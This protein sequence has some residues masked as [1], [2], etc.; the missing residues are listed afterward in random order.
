MILEFGVVAKFLA[1]HKYIGIKCFGA[2]HLWLWYSIS[3]L[4]I[5]RGA[6]ALKIFAIVGYGLA[7][8]NI[9]RKSQ[10]CNAP[11]YLQTNV[12][13]KGQRCSAP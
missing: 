7:Q 10:M 4:Q 6:A 5:L 3:I 13:A 1:G 2:L 11:E 9:C 8:R 12:C